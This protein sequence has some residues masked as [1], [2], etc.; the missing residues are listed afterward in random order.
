MLPYGVNEVVVFP[1]LVL[2]DL[3]PGEG[4]AQEGQA[5]AGPRRG[6]Q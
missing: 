2:L 6:L 3:L 5:L 4:G 1:G